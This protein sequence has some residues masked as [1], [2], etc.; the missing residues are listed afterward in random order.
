MEKIY[1]IK[2]NL[3]EEGYVFNIDAYMGE[4]TNKAYKWTGNLIKKSLLNQVDTINRNFGG[5]ISFYCWSLGAEVENNKRQL[6]EKC[7][8]R[9]AYLQDCIYKLSKGIEINNGQKIHENFIQHDHLRTKPAPTRTRF[10][11]GSQNYSG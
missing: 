10:A 5:F 9:L 11:K 6:L 4:E 7:Y 1:K 2:I 3:R 8:E